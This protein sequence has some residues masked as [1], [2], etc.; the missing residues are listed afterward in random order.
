MIVAVPIGD[1][2]A[3]RQRSAI[4]LANASIMLPL[5]SVIDWAEESGSG[6]RP[7]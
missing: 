2:L 5:P 7:I 1:P 4:P 6:H 3:M